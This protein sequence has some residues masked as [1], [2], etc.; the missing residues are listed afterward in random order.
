M[1]WFLI[2]P[3]SIC[4]L[5]L[6]TLIWHLQHSMLLFSNK[7]F[8]DIAAR[9]NWV[10]PQSFVGPTCTTTKWRQGIV[11]LQEPVPP[12]L[13]YILLGR[14]KA[15]LSNAPG[16]PTW[17][18]QFKYWFLC[19]QKNISLIIPGTQ[20]V[21]L[22]LSVFLILPCDYVTPCKHAK[23]EKLGPEKNFFCWYSEL[24]SYNRQTHLLFK[25]LNNYWAISDF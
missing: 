7:H 17:I 8:I 18:K 21:L 9:K 3:Q 15:G 14:F 10:A 1:K 11:M 20:I 25:R 2:V 19:T 12:P 24:S 6:Y 16:F 5:S 23:H 13:L 4:K 22:K